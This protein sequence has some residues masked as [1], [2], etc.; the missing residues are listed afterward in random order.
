MDL[1][2]LSKA[3]AKE[4]K[5]L[6][7]KKERDKQGLFLVEGEKSI[8]MLLD[9]FPLEAL[10]CTDEWLRHNEIISNRYSSKIMLSDRRGI[11]IISSMNSL[12][13]V[14]AVFKKHEVKESEFELDP[15][16]LYLLLDEIQDPGNLGTIIRTCDW[17]GVYDIFASENTVDAYSPKVVQASMGSLARVRIHYSDL[18]KLIDENSHI[19]VIGTLLSGIP[20]GE[21]Q[22]DLRGLLLMGNE[23]RGI[24]D[25]LKMKI[26]VPVTIPPVNPQYHPDSLNVGIATAIILS[27]LTT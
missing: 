5:K 9:F 19:N 25:K 15:S 18:T 16:K 27:Y 26:D 12:P 4:L 3:K 17:F 14:I 7:L 20:L 8:E 13:E 24:S 1:L 21:L 10:I 2:T 6:S 22:K 11:E 23:G